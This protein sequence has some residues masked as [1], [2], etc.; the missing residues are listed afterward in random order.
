MS[1][2]LSREP[3]LQ[4]EGF[5]GR[6][7]ELAWVTDMLSRPSPQNSNMIGEPRIGKTSFLYQIAARQLGLRP[8][9][10]GLHVW[11]RLAELPDHKAH[12]FWRE[13]LARLA[14]AQQAAGFKAAAAAAAAEADDR[15]IFDALDE[16]L[17]ELAESDCQRLFLLIDDFDLLLR[18]IGSRDLDW[19]RS[20][21][22]RHSAW[23]A[24]VITSSESLVVLEDKIYQR[25][26]IETHVSPFANIFHSRPLGLLTLAEAAHLCRD[27]AVAEYRALLTDAD[28]AFLLHEAGPHPALL[29][30]TCSYL[31]EARQYDQG[32]DVYQDVSGDVRLDDQVN[33][34]CRQLWLRRTP[35]EQDV[36]AH[37]AQGQVVEVDTILLTRLKKH[38]GLIGVSGERPALFAEAFAYWVRRELG[39]G[40]EGS[41]KKETAVPTGELTYLPH[42]RL[43]YVDDREVHLTA[44]EGRLLA[45]LIEHKNEVCTVKAL[46]EN[47]WGP[48]KTRSVVEK[49]VNRLRLKI[50]HDPKRP[51]FIL[52]ARGEGYLL[53]LE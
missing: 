21:A 31:F 49:A 37:L 50:E 24:F 47:V 5:V 15:A 27:T 28:L 32:D 33:W 13:M 51:R 41:M 1:G 38:L 10:K 39:K 40:G 29:K 26:G 34:L 45:Y 8:G 16:L 3:V 2:Y 36:L 46:Q 9:Q 20:L 11:L 14:Q 19:L 4:I 30:I 23:L 25:E 43:A 17:D 22:T 12:T 18:G 44:L 48:G 7:A 42:E 35:E 52:S 6:L 53:R